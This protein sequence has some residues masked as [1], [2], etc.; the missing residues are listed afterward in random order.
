MGNNLDKNINK[1][2]SGK[3]SQ[4]LLDHAKNLQQIHL[5]LLQKKAIQKT[6]DTLEELIGNIIA[7]KITKVSKSSPQNNSESETEIPKEKYITL[8][9]RQ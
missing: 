1:N 4:K 7:T 5:K 2:L 9:E 3:C 6:T 8:E